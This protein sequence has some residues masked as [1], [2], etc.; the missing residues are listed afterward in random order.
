MGNMRNNTNIEILNKMLEENDY[1]KALDFIESIPPKERECW[2]I[3][4]ILGMICYYLNQFENADSFFRQALKLNQD[5]PFIYFNMAYL[6]I[7][8]KKYKHA[9]LMLDFVLYISKDEENIS[10]AKKLH[11]EIESYSSD[12]N[13]N[14][15]ALMVAYY[16]PPL[17]GSGVFRSI[18]FVKNLPDLG[19]IPTVIST[20][21][22]P[23]GWNFRDDSMTDEIPECADVHRIPD[24]ISTGRKTELSNKDIQP[25]LNLLVD[26]FKEDIDAIDSI[27]QLCRTNE[28]LLSLLNFP[29]S[30]LIWA[31]DVINY[32]EQNLSLDKYDIIYTTSGPS[33]SHLIGYYFKKK[34]NIPWVAD[35]RDAWTNNPYFH[36]DSANLMHVLLRKMEGI[37][38]QTADHNITISTRLIDEYNKEFNVE[39]N[40]ISCITNG[41][42]ENDFEEITETHIKN[43]KFTITYSGL[44]YTEQRNVEP[45][46]IAL[47][48]LIE[49]GKIDRNKITLQIIGTTD[50]EHNNFVS[51]KYG[52]S[53]ILK[54][55][56]Y[57][58]HEKALRYN[59]D[60]D[61][62]LL[63]VGDEDRF[64]SV[65]TGKVFDYLRSGKPILALAPKDGDVDEL[66]NFT[67]HGKVFYSYDNE[68]IQKYI[69]KKYEL[70]LSSDK[71][72]FELSTNIYL[73]ERKYLT[74]K[75]ADIFLGNMRK[76]EEIP[77]DVYNDA[78]RSGGAGGNYHRSYKDSFYYFSS[79]KSAEDSRIRS[80]R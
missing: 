13:L 32:I 14:N 1:A 67:N 46:L 20:D 10:E 57:V 12:E 75:L 63:L 21:T 26:V 16:F 52:L 2:E 6:Y 9:K 56:G 76:T 74:M 79:T 7:S 34:Y 65:Y 41:F 45:V 23:D 39:N 69:L 37:L 38:L 60:S 29:C 42:D 31:C 53:D 71:N 3:K 15:N 73:Y 11:K 8:M 35:Y 78:Y 61:M 62:L 36:F 24:Y 25:A 27:K 4:N 64:K 28:G 59:I 48:K 22:P 55:E 49:S 30:C 77:C 68:E 50:K 54:Q 72:T 44:L 66:L 18:K 40:R 47:S 17:S 58:S 33:S 51:G 43:S 19:W 5:N 70:W 80:M